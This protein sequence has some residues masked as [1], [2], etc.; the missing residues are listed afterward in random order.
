ME[1]RGY[2]KSDQQL[3]QSGVTPKGLVITSIKVAAKGLDYKKR[4]IL[5]NG[6]FYL[7]NQSFL[8]Y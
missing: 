1:G 6:Y 2:K 5:Y 8:K 3:E 4:E 7:K